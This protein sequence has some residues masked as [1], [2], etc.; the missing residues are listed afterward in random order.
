MIY[1]ITCQRAKNY[2]AVLQTYALA[3]F[4]D[5]LGY[6]VQVIDYKPNYLNVS[7]TNSGFLFNLARTI[8][9]FPDRCRGE[10]VFKKFLNDYVPLTKRTF[11]TCEDI[12]ENLPYGSLYIAGS[13]QI[14]NMNCANGND[15]SYFLSFAPEKAKKASYAASL[16]MEQLSNEQKKRLVDMT[17]DFNAVSIREKSGKEL[18]ENATNRFADLVLDPVFLLD[19]ES[20][21]S[22]I[23]EHEEKDKYLLVY[24]FY[25][26]KEVFEYARK[27]ANKMKCRVYF[28]NT[29]YLDCLMKYDKYFWCVSP[30]EFLTLFNNAESV[31]TNSFHGIAF[32]LIFHKDLHVFL[33]K[34]TG[35]SRINDFLQVLGLDSRIVKSDELIDSKIDYKKI[36]SLLNEKIDH[37]KSFLLKLL[38]DEQ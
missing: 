10:Y 9:Q 32:S 23:N 20:W 12:K 1:T 24:A 17:T 18:F 38:D 11:S 19:K 30:N 27:L 25:R 21:K 22:I 33:P 28:V 8:I 6:P 4:I 34:R 5:S 29:A 14:W 35:N 7:Q 37:S 16:A 15:D 26:H 2:G 36:D 3:K 13:D 31:V